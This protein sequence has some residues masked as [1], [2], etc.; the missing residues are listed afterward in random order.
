MGLRV[1]GAGLGRTG[2][3]SLK[4]GLERLTGEPCYHMVEV[5]KH[6]DHC[7]VWTEAAKGNIPDWNQFLTGYGSAVDWPSAAFWKEMYDALP[8]S[9]VVLSVRDPQEW[10]D[11]ASSTIFQAIGHMPDPSWHEMIDTIMANRSHIDMVHADMCI[12]SFQ[13]HNQAVI[14][15]VAP[16]RLVVWNAKDGWEPLCK[17]LGVPV[18]NEPFPKTNTRAEFLQRMHDREQA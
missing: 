8:G 11:S 18:P 16:E 17:A 5:F 13:A 4:L 3:H 10:W 9:I 1:I 6:M 2:T 15:Y 7:P 12:A 14:D